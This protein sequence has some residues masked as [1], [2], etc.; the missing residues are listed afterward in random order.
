MLQSVRQFGSEHS[1]RREAS[2]KEVRV[3]PAASA[4]NGSKGGRLERLTY[5]DFTFCLQGSTGDGAPRVFTHSDSHKLYEARA[6]QGTQDGPERAI[7]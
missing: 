7:T 3:S 4:G 1:Q 5:G 2:I 6:S